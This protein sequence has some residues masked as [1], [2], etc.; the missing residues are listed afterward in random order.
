MLLSVILF[1]LSIPGNVFQWFTSKMMIRSLDGFVTSK[2]DQVVRSFEDL[3]QHTVLYSTSISVCQPLTWLISTILQLLQL[4]ATIPPTYI[5]ICNDKS[6]FESMV[7]AS[8]LKVVA[9][10]VSQVN[11][12]AGIG[13]VTW[14]WKDDSDVVHTQRVE[15]VHYFSRMSSHHCFR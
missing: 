9:I 5:H 2:R 4:F 1:C 13:T 11:V 12:P 3:V 7:S 8:A 15:Q 6:M 10:I 14:S